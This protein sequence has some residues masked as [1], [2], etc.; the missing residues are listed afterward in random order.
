MPVVISPDQD[1]INAEVEIKAPPE[2]V[3]EALVDSAQARGWG[4]TEG[5]TVTVW[6]LEPRVGGKWKFVAKDG[7]GKVYEHYGEVLAFDPPRLLEHT[8]IAD[9]H[10]Q[11]ARPTVVRWELTASGNGT[12]LK[13]SH[14]G[15]AAQPKVR[16]DYKSGW[17]GLLE[18]IKKYCEK[19][20]AN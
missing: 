3:F 9:F 17:P 18:A 1:A 7:G 15:F 19:A 4:S 12:V 8:W 20:G 16:K 2:R 11:P 6:E 10:D 14:R 5:F 13:V